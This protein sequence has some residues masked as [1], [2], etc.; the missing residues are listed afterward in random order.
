MARADA[1]RGVAGDYIVKAGSVAEARR[2]VRAVGG[3]PTLEFAII[4]AVGARLAAAQVARLREDPRLTITLDAPVRTQGGPVIDQYARSITGVNQLAAQGF[5]GV[6]VTVA[7][8][9]TG[10]WYSRNEVNNDL[11]GKNKIL[12]MYDAIAR[13]VQN[14]PDK[15]GHGS[16]VASIIGSPQYSVDGQPLGMAPMARLVAVKAFDTGRDRQLLDGAERPE[17]GNLSS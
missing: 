9:D 14:T 13:K 16:H 10:I 7:I 2:A 12:V 4:D 11:N 17:P 15:S 5:T 8:L 1:P 6:G 3:R